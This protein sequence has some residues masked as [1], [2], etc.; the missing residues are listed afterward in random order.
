MA[1]DAYQELLRVAERLREM[2]DPDFAII[3]AGSCAQSAKRLRDQFIA[4]LANRLRAILLNTSLVD[5]AADRAVHMAAAAP[6][7]I[8]VVA[9]GAEHMDALIEQAEQAAGV[10]RLGWL[11]GA[12]AGAFVRRILAADLS[13]RLRL[14]DGNG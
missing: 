8:E 2:D 14:V 10:R 4:D 13:L 12:D 3:A 5:D 1:V 9:Q 6:S 11:V 7:L